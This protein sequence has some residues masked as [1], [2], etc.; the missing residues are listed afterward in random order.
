LRL[1]LFRNL[2]CQ[3]TYQLAGY[4]K[5]DI[6]EP[7]F[8]LNND[9]TMDVPTKQGIGVEVN[10]KKIERVTVKKMPLPSLSMH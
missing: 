2:P 3:P 7:E 8:I 4:F 9:G 6:I 5:E 10:M 1:P